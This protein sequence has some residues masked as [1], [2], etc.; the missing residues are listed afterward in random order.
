MEISEAISTLFRRGK[1]LVLAGNRNAIPRFFGQ[2]H[3]VIMH[4]TKLARIE[5][6]H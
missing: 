4:P 6:R 1:I 2:L 5:K 3:A